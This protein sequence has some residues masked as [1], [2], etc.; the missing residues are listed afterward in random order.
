MNSP[1]FV[2]WSDV[3]FHDRWVRATKGS[4]QSFDLLDPGI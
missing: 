4:D 2:A 3:K 1:E